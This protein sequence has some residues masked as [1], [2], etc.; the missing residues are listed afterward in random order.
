MKLEKLSVKSFRN[1]KEAELVPHSG[2]NII[3]GDNAQGKT[4]L[5]EAIYLLTGQKSF[6]QAKESD[7][8]LF[9]EERAEI[10]ADFFAGGRQ[11]Q[12][13]LTIG[14]KRAATLNEVPVTPSELTGRF[15]AVVFSPT[16]L[17]LIKEGPA[18]RR[19]FLDSA[20]SQVMPRYMKTLGSMNRA[21]FQRNSLL[22]DMRGRSGMEDMLSVWDKS[23]AKL[24]FTVINARRRYV[25]RL[26]PHAQ[27]IYTGISSGKETL[28]V[29]YQ[30]SIDAPW[31]ELSSAEGE[32]AILAGLQKSRYEDIKNG[33]TTVGP[34]RDDLE[35]AVNGSSARS[36]GSQ[37]QQRSCALT[38]K[39]AE[40]AVIKE[41]SGEAPIVLLDDVFSELDKGRRDFFLRGM[42]DGQSFITCCDRSALRGLT[43]GKSFRVRSG[44]PAETRRKKKREG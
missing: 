29:T 13:T 6:R 30:C 17:A 3:Y 16:E 32:A 5:I 35:I 22:S 21:L 23:F 1:I 9:G 40:C 38:L 26:L 36:F 39:L 12:A 20:I 37:G 18:T 28:T 19:A 8:V 31:E 14:G 42:G 2:V 34:H 25:A 33:F 43:E 41:V 24:A 11:Q 27:E 15:F 7:L 44:E 4:N 10:S